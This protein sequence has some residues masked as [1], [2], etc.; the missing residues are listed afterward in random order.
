[1]FDI[2]KFHPYIYKD[3]KVSVY[4]MFIVYTNLFID[5]LKKVGTNLHIQDVSMQI[6]VAMKYNKII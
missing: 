3:L 4:G 1:M 2:Y 5:L 6:L